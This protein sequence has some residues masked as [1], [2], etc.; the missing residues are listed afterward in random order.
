MCYLYLE[1]LLPLEKLAGHS[2]FIV[3]I[4]VTDISL[5]MRAE[6]TGYIKTVQC[7]NIVHCYIDLT[8]N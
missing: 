7:S 4:L 5:G 8:T 3:K 2:I 1:S 6:K